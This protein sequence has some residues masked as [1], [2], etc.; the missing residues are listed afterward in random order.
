M[1]LQQPIQRATSGTAV[2]PDSYLGCIVRVVTATDRGPLTSL[3]A[4]GLVDGKNQ[5]NRLEFP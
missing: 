2:E 4:F 3:S 5:K 1:F